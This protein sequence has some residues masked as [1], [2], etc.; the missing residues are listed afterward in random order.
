MKT[1]KIN[2]LLIGITL[3]ALIYFFIWGFGF[4]GNANK[5]I[6]VISVFLGVFMAFNIGGNDVANS[7]GTSVG[8]GTLTITQEIGR[9][10]V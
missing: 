5:L 9:A 4:I 1:Q 7:F 2:L 3:G 8:S 6:F 10:H